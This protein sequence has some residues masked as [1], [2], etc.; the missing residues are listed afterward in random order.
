MIFDKITRNKLTNRKKRFLFC[1]LVPVRECT[2]VRSINKAR[3][4]RYN[5]YHERRAKVEHFC[6]GNTLALLIKLEKN[7]YRFLF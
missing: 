6:C 4:K 1:R 2:M 7:Y 5:T 3:S